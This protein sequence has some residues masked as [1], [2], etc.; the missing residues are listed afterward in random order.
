VLVLLLI[1]FSTGC[2]TARKVRTFTDESQANS[3]LRIL[4]QFE[5]DASKRE[6][7]EAGKN[8]TI[9]VPDSEFNMALEL[10]EDFCIGSEPAA[11]ADETTFN[12]SPEL[13]KSISEAK[14]KREIEENLRT[15]PFVRCVNVALNFPEGRS[16]SVRPYPA[17]AAVIVQYVGTHP[18]VNSGEIAQQIARSVP[19]LAVEN[20]QV[21]LIKR[22]TRY[23][24]E[25]FRRLADE[26]ERRSTR[27]WMIGGTFGITLILLVTL[28][29]AIIRQL[30]PDRTELYVEDEEEGS[31]PLNQDT[32]V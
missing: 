17:Q 28:F 16:L 29:L 22:P 5:I 18:P 12:K 9:E 20:V 11:L 14:R 7:G 24:P 30:K 27:R 31:E 19:D 32:N 8:W 2:A 23:E 4:L 3:L 15:L 1:L 25:E 13:E 21:T 10:M 6:S 26:R